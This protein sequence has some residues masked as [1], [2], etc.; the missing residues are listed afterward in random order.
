MSYNPQNLYQCEVEKRKIKRKHVDTIMVVVGLFASVSSIPQ[1]I[2]IFQTGDVA[3]ISLLTQVIGLA[4]VLA[5]FS[6]GFYIKNRPLV[7]TT[8]VTAV[9]L[10]VVVVQILVYA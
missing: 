6:Y 5:W 8:S 10:F 7:I 2:K 9:V 4:S 3:G 1:A